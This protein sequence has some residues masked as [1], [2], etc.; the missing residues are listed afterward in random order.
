MR[1]NVLIIKDII[2]I[3][4]PMSATRS[5]SMSLTKLLVK[6]GQKKLEI[7]ILSLSMYLM[8]FLGVITFSSNETFPE[9]LK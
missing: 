2:I 1:L 6:Q 5:L 8:N 9:L 3:I 4:T 7:L